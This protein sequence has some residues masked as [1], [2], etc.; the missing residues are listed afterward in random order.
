MLLRSVSDLNAEAVATT[1]TV[2]FVEIFAYSL[3]LLGFIQFVSYLS[4]GSPTH[5]SHLGAPKW[6]KNFVFLAVSHLIFHVICGF[7]ILSQVKVKSA[8]DSL[9]LR[10]EHPSPKCLVV[11]QAMF[12]I[13][14][15]S[16]I[17]CFLWAFFAKDHRLLHAVDR[18]FVH[19]LNIDMFGRLSRISDIDE[20]RKNMRLYISVTFLVSAWYNFGMARLMSLIGHNSGM[21][22][23]LKG[24]SLSPIKSPKA[25]NGDKLL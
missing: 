15:I 21:A 7:V 4:C 13:V 8:L 10:L 19:Y 18:G 1:F 2:T 12:Y 3:F 24:L 23:A 22:Y 5:A 9:K 16:S 20:F 6:D 17:V 14:S 11:V 25:E